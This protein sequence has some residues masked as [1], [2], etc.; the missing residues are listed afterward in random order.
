MRADCRCYLVHNKSIVVQLQTFTMPAGDTPTGDPSLGVGEQFKLLENLLQRV[1][2]KDILTTPQ[3]NEKNDIKSHLDKMRQYFNM[4][5]ISAEETKITLLFNTL[6][7]DMR[8]ELCGAL[9]F[10][11]HENDYDWIEKKLLELFC[12]KETEITPLVKL[13][14]HKQS[15]S[16]TIREFLSEIRIEGYKLFKDMDPKT[17]EKHLLDAFMKGLYNKEL[18]LALNMKE[19]ETL[20]EAYHLVKKEKQS[21]NV[22]YVRKIEMKADTQTSEMEKLQNQILMLQKQMSYIVTILES[23]RAP[24][25]PS[26]ANVTRRKQDAGGLVDQNVRVGSREIPSRQTR[27]IQCWNCG[28]NGHISRNCKFNRCFSCGQIGHEARN[29]RSRRQ[30]RRVRRIWEDKGDE[31]WD[32]YSPESKILDS[33]SQESDVSNSQE[34]PEVCALTIHPSGTNFDDEFTAQRKKRTT[35]MTNK[36]NKTY[37]GYIVELEEFVEGRR[38]KRR[39]CLEEEKRTAA[40]VAVQKDQ[41]KPLVRGKCEGKQAKLFLDTGAEI[42]VV[43]EGF[44]QQLKEQPIRRHRQTKVIKC[45]NNSRM[46]TKGWVKLRIQVGGQEKQCKFWVVQSLYPKIII[47]IKAMKDMGISI[48]PAKECVWVNG[49]KVPFSARVQPQSLL[50]SK[51]GNARA[52]G[53]RVEGRQ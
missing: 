16:Q 39:T 40:A 6:M 17:R 22:D 43:D 46:D 36:R 5:G 31:E 44:L 38:S 13:Y 51:S 41:N 42:S 47:G 2:R 23:I 45:A 3:L 10:K 30:T 37:P 32:D 1:L 4:C 14:A 28:K 53:L 33:S 15:S 19:V 29:C 26:Y 11:A 34:I 52:P 25:R 24:S 9:E 18:R 20:D 21:T 49:R 27:E 7:D 12:P 50:G 35:K 8:F 48:D